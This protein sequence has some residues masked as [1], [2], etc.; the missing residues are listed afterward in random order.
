M[1]SRGGVWVREAG[2]I[3]FL[4]CGG[5]YWGLRR[6]KAMEQDLYEE[7]LAQVAIDDLTGVFN[8]RFLN[9]HLDDVLNQED[10]VYVI[11]IDLDDFKELNDSMGHLAGN[12]LLRTIADRLKS[13]LREGDILARWG[14]DEFVVVPGALLDR[15]QAEMLADRIRRNISLACAEFL[16]RHKGEGHGTP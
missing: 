14:G 13:I 12:E 8:H 1:P 9:A 2:L 11:M 3:S 6:L 15:D 4:L 16:E 10:Q 7:L 5:G